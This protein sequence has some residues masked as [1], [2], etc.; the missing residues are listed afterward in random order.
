MFS[1]KKST[2]I[3]LKLICIVLAL[4]FVMTG[5]ALAEDKPIT[6][7]IDGEKVEFDAQPKMVNDRVMVPLRAIFEKLD[8]KVLWDP[9]FERVFINYNEN[10]EIIM[11]INEEVVFKNG[12]QVHLD[13]PAFISEGRTY[14]PLRFIAE[15]LDQ[16]VEWSDSNYTVYIVPKDK[17]MQ[18]VPFGEFLTIPCPYSVNRN[19]K[20]LEYDNTTEVVKATYSLNGENEADFERYSLIM[21]A[22]GFKTVKQATEDDARII[23]HGKGVVVT[24]NLPDEEGIFSAELYEDYEGATVKDYLEGETENE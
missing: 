3:L 2:G 13:S 22:C 24:I 16:S 12:I 15:S 6:V 23:Y 11:Y 1:N 9:L 18:Y 8:A 10:D 21:E 4:T 17:A 5:V 7:L 14:V 20:T 19:Y